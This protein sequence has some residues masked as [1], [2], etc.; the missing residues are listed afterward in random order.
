MRKGGHVN[1]VRDVDSHDADALSPKGFA[2]GLL[3]RNFHSF[4]PT[5]CVCTGPKPL[6]CTITSPSQAPS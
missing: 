3:R 6:I 2:L 1:G 5:K 4:P